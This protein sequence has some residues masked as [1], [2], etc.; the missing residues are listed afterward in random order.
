MQPNLKKAIIEFIANE[1]KLN[2]EGM[3]PDLSFTIDLGLDAEHFS[4]L[5]QRLQDSLDFTLPEDKI[6]EIFTIDDI[7]TILSEP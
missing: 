3:N 4:D 6:P 7:F 5:L 1:F 2:P